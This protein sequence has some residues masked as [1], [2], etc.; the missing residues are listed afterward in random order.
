MQERDELKTIYVVAEGEATEYDYLAHL[1]R[2]HGRRLHF[3]IKPPPRA[4]QKNGLHPRRVVEEATRML[5]KEDIEEVWA[6][7]DHDGRPGIPQVCAEARRQGVRVA[8][9][10]PAFELW[11]LLHFDN[12]VPA[13]QGGDNATIMTNLRKTHPA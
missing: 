8:L 1:N 7:F 10:H 12:Q 13:A 9:S 4:T 5:D 6:L 11:L 2:T 3:R